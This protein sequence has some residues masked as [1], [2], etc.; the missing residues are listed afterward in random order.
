[1]DEL[2]QESV[3]RYATEN[4]DFGFEMKALR[5]LKAYDWDVEHSGTYVDPISKKNREFDLR[6]SKQFKKWP[7]KVWLNVECK[8][9][10]PSFP[11]IVQTVQRTR[12]A[13]HEIIHYTMNGSQPQV[14]RSTVFSR[15]KNNQDD[16]V[17]KS[18]D[19]VRL[20]RKKDELVSSDG[21]TFDKMSQALNS[22]HGLIQR[23]VP[24]D[25]KKDARFVIIPVLVIPDNCLWRLRYND[26]GEPI[27]EPEKI[28][29]TQYFIDQ[30]WPIFLQGIEADYTMSHLE[31]VTISSI[32][33]FVNSLVDDRDQRTTFLFRLEGDSRN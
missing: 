14:A 20:D 10:A 19:Q 29:S 3:K 28:E 24:S 33:K 21:K 27:G 31:I 23:S 15:Y 22:A 11:L 9:I 16:W 2:T 13:F 26:D 17:A 25:V 32:G 8:N 30:S 4:T 1:M 6:A 12:E 18:F 7:Y 5:A